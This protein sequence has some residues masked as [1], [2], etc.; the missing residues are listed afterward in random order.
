MCLRRHGRAL[1]GAFLL[2]ALVGGMSG[3]SSLCSLRDRVHCACLGRPLLARL[4]STPC[5]ETEIISAQPVAEPTPAP[6]VCSQP[7]VTCSPCSPCQPYC[8]F[9]LRNWPFTWRLFNHYDEGV[10]APV[11]AA[12]EAV[13][14]EKIAAPKSEAPKPA[15]QPMPTMPPPSGTAPAKP[16]EGAM[17]E[18]RT[19]LV[20]RIGSPIRR[21][22]RKLLG[23]HEFVYDG[24]T[25][26]QGSFEVIA[27]LP[28]ERPSEKPVAERQETTNEVHWALGAAPTNSAVQPAAAADAATKETQ[29]KAL[30][31]SLVEIRGSSS[32]VVKVFDLADPVPVGND[33]DYLIQVTNQGTLPAL[34]LK[35]RIECPEEVQPVSFTNAPEL[36]AAG[37]NIEVP[38]FDLAACGTKMFRLRVH[39]VK[40]GDVRFRVHLQ[41]QDLKKEIQEEETTRLYSAR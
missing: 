9:T 35:L 6:V 39:V 18:Q 30:A 25:A 3:C 2:I 13:Q 24:M 21:C 36:K 26:P 34:D 41:G 7:C 11:Y 38:S 19:D 14:A 40:G 20:A 33:L 22:F 12:P 37:Q 31:A 23:E 32:V 15:T 16:M 1:A 4:H 28:L 10:P 17:I 8:H 5:C 29:S 27:A